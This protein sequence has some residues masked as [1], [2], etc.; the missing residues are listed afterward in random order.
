MIHHHVG[1]T[2]ISRE[3]TPPLH[4][5]E[6]GVN[7]GRLT[8]SALP[9]ARRFRFGRGIDP[10]SPVT[11]RT[12]KGC[13]KLLVLRLLWIKGIQSGGDIVAAGNFLQN[14]LQIGRFEIEINRVRLL[15]Q[16]RFYQCWH[17]ARKSRSNSSA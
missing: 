3:P 17:A 11:S 10:S 1:S 9:S 5:G 4:I 14:L 8:A 7:P 2:Q 6:D 15:G 12:S 16:T 13:L